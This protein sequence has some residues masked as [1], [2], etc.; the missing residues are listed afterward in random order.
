MTQLVILCTSGIHEQYCNH[1]IVPD[2]P[3]CSAWRLPYVLSEMYK[4]KFQSTYHLR[5]SLQMFQ[6]LHYR[7]PQMPTKL[8]SE[9]AL[10][11]SR[12]WIRKYLRWYVD[13]GCRLYVL[14]QT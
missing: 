14:E 1:K 6:A 11:C 5:Y 2:P 10:Q 12:H 3:T 9:A 4:A 13:W 8:V 7:V